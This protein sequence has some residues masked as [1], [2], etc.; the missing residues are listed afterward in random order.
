MLRCIF[1][2]STRALLLRLISS[3]AMVPPHKPR[4]HRANDVLCMFY[5]CSSCDTKVAFCTYRESLC[6]TPDSA[7]IDM[8]ID[9]L[10]SP[11]ITSIVSH[12]HNKVY[13][14][15]Q[16]YNCGEGHPWRATGLTRNRTYIQR[17]NSP[18]IS[19]PPPQEEFHNGS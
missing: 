9:R 18:Q 13:K 19:T 6:R 4:K 10:H 16:P 8:T 5:A 15:T 2:P 17:N 12:R 1:C 3:I 7:K 11:T 14:S